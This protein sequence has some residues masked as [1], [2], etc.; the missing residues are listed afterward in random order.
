[1]IPEIQ[2]SEADDEAVLTKLEEALT[3]LQQYREDHRDYHWTPHQV[4]TTTPVAPLATGP[5]TFTLLPRL[6]RLSRLIPRDEKMRMTISLRFPRSYALL[7]SI[8]AALA[9]FMV[10]QSSS[11]GGHACRRWSQRPAYPCSMLFFRLKVWHRLYLRLRGLVTRAF[12][13]SKLQFKGLITIYPGFHTLSHDVL[14]LF[15]WH[16]MGRMVVWCSWFP[17]TMLGWF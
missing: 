14:L 15:F 16:C 5:T 7:L 10:Q 9:S 12:L 8:P 1:L 4:K 17:Y 13:A 11:S 2:A 3:G 6:E